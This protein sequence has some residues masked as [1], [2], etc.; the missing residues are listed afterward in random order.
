MRDAQKNIE[1]Q[2]VQPLNIQQQDI[3]LISQYSQVSEQSVEY[4]LKKYIYADQK[5]WQ[6]LLQ[7]LL[8]GLGV[9][10][11]IAGII[12]FF[13][14]NWAD[15]HKFVKIGLIEGLLI[16]VTLLALIRT[17]DLSIRNMILTGTAGLVGVLFA[18]F[19]QIYQTGANAYD[20]FLAWTIFIGLWVIVSHYTVLWLLF[21]VLIN[22]TLILYSQQIADHWSFISI[23]TLLLLINGIV[24]IIAIYLSQVKKYDIPYWFLNMITLFITCCATAGISIGIFDPFN[25]KLLILMVLTTVF[26]ISI[27]YYALNVKH[28][29]YLAVIP[30]SLIVIF[31]A[32]ILRGFESHEVLLPISVFIIIA[33]TLIIKNLMYL[34]QKWK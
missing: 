26:Y 7:W 31:S 8:L 17:F 14:Y 15:L 3:H 13:A 22:T 27:V 25:H 10:F 29:F 4:T 16:V 9:S 21:L 18:V 24:L 20:F 32:F 11:L 12:F 33:V 5:S 23:N 34:Q 30:F 28:V 6:A 1:Q 19:G 2:N